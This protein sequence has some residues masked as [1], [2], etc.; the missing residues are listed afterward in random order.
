MEKEKGSVTEIMERLERRRLNWKDITTIIVAVTVLSGM[1]MS[2]VG[3]IHAEVTIPKI[4]NRTAAQINKA[5][6]MHSKFSHPVSVPRREF[7][8][9][10]AVLKEDIGKV[11]AAVKEFK[12]DNKARLDRIEEKIDRNR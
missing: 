5:I 12:T 10:T 1:L 3:W 2:I 7:N 6:E 8:I 4:L 11:E 9:F